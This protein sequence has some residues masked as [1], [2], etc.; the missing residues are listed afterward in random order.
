[1]D[2]SDVPFFMRQDRPKFSAVERYVPSSPASRALHFGMLGVQLAGG[3][4]AEAFKQKT[5][6]STNNTG[7]SG[8][9]G[10]ALNEKNAERLAANFKKMRGGALKIG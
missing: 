2:Y 6:L 4:M 9:A 5:G 7:K 10:Y 8:I 1:M 3:T